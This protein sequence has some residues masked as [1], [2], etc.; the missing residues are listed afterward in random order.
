MVVKHEFTQCNHFTFNNALLFTFISY[1]N[2]EQFDWKSGFFENIYSEIRLLFL[3]NYI[4]MTKWAEI[5]KTN[6]NHIH[7]FVRKQRNNIKSHTAARIFRHVLLN[8]LCFNSFLHQVMKIYRYIYFFYLSWWHIHKIY[9]H[10]ANKAV[11]VYMNT[12]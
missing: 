12:Q 6:D 2:F 3:N 5:N 4:P 7:G 1:F 10:K 9:I 11:G 8:A